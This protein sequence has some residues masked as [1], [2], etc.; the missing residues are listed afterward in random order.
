LGYVGTES[1][2][3]KEWEELGPEVFAMPLAEAG[4]DGAVRL[5][6]DDFDYRI[7]IHPG[8]ADRLAYTGWE[9]DGPAELEEY[10]VGLRRQGITVTPAVQDECH[11]RRVG[12]MAYFHDPVG[13]RFEVYFGLYERE[14]S[15]VAPRVHGGFVTGNNGMGHVGLVVP[16]GEAEDMFLTSALGFRKSDTTLVSPD[17]TSRFYFVNPRHHSLATV[18]LRGLRG[19]H[20]IMVEVC[21]LDDVGI[22]WDLVKKREDM[23]FILTLGRHSTDRALS[24]YARTPCGFAIEYGWGVR[25]IDEHWRPTY[26]TFPSEIWGHEFTDLGATPGAVQTVGAG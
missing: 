12:G 9:V 10:A 11:E 23:P 3:Y 19:L 25:Q 6:L 17:Y 1:P 21:D 8:P 16:D 26:T 24:F 5:R 13:N 7:A 2:R 18:P 22:A 15:F 4:T 14:R 20:H